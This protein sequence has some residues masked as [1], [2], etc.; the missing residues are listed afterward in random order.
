MPAYQVLEVMNE[1]T[2]AA[3]STLP[4]TVA[5]LECDVMD[6]TDVDDLS[7]T[8]ECTFGA[9]ATGDAVVHIRTSPYGGPAVI[10]DWDTVDFTSF[11]LTCDPGKRVQKTVVI[12][13]DP[14]NM[15]AMVENKDAAVAITDVIVTKVTT[16]V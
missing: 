3:A 14:K 13:A 16:G 15:K 7:V 5:G 8:V 4:S 9:L 11:T 10:T 2:L 1:A 12:E 6:M